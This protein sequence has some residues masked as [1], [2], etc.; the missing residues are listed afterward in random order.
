MPYA[1]SNFQQHIYAK[2]HNAS[3][4][5]VKTHTRYRLK[6]DA[7]R[8]LILAIL[9]PLALKLHVHQYQI[10]RNNRDF[11]CFFLKYNLP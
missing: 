10:N 6:T 2:K 8:C 4:T 3:D 5:V 1:T 9:T 11:C 7:S